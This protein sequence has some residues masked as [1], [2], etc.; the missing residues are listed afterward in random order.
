MP[1]KT[2][3]SF[4]K[5][6]LGTRV[7]PHS[8]EGEKYEKNAIAQL[9]GGQTN[10]NRADCSPALPLYPRT[11]RQ[12]KPFV[13]FVAPLSLSLRM[14]FSHKS[15]QLFWRREQRRNPG[16]QAPRRAAIQDPVVKA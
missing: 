5:L 14:T 9:K 6:V 15:L 12:S 8:L 16:E 4:V 2:S 13:S 7:K 1:L 11:R 10:D 3:I